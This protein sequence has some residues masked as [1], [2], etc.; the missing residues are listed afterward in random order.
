[1]GDKTKY[2]IGD[3]TKQ[4]LNWNALILLGTLQSKEKIQGPKQK[5]GIAHAPKTY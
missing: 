2:N 3:K 5:L 1:M 4:G